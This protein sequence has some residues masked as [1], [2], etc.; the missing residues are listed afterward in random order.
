VHRRFLGDDRA[1]RQHRGDAEDHGGEPPS[2][3]STRPAAFLGK[4]VKLVIYDDV[5]EPARA[6]DNARRIGESDNCVIMMVCGRTPNAIALREAAGGNGVALE[7][8]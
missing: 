5:G 6:V 2:T 7:W 3:R 4:P 1:A 8:G